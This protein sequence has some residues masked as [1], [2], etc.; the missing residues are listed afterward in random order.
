VSRAAVTG[1]LTRLA[2]ARTVWLDEALEVIA[3]HR[4]VD[5][6][7]LEGSL[8]RGDGDAF[9]DIDLVVAVGSSVPPAVFAEPV[10]GLG[11]P[12]RLLYSRGKP[13][14]APAGGAFRTVCFELAALPILVDLYLWPTVTATMS[15]TARLLYR[16][17]DAR[18]PRSS[19]EFLPLISRYPNGDTQGSDPHQ[20]ETA[21]M[22]VQLAAKYLARGDDER[23]T[24]VLRQLTGRP[25][26]AGTAVLRELLADRVGA[27]AHPHLRAALAAA[28]RLI[29]VAEHSPG[30]PLP[31]GSSAQ[32]EEIR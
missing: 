19:L 21:L 20:P 15:A 13:K 32:A 10:S 12:G 28:H 4:F 7:W 5:A 27:T 31:T 17:D 25:A 16:H 23:H 2:D 11:L 3:S 8:G 14:N 6:V 9:S 24:T 1:A 30:M 26:G 22:L 29:D 18:P